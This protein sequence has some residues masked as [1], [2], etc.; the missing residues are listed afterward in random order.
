MSEHPEITRLRANPIY[1]T[2]AGYHQQVDGLER[3]IVQIQKALEAEGITGAWAERI[4]SR[5]LYSQPNGERAR[6]GR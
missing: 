1:F 4:L 5:V 2:D 6:A 3:T